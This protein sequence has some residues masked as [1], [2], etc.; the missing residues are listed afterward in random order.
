[1]ES[2]TTYGRSRWSKAWWLIPAGLLLLGPEAIARVVTTIAGIVTFPITGEIGVEVNRYEIFN[3]EL[4]MVYMIAAVGVNLIALPGLLSIGQAAFFGLGAYTVAI[5]T[6]DHGWNFWLALAAGAVLSALVSVVLAVPALR[7]GMFTLAMVTLG[8]GI[9]FQSM[10]LQLIDLT[11]GG[12]GIQGVAMPDAFADLESY[13]WLLAIVLG[14]TVALSVTVLRS[15]MGRQL[16]AVGSAP[17]AA[18][19]IGIHAKR[20]KLA[21]FAAAGFL[22]GLAGGLYAPLIGF[23]SPESFTVDL[24]ILLLLM[25]LL[26]GA[27]TIVGPLLGAVL[28]FRIPIEVNRVTDDPGNTS[29]LVYGI[30]LLL[31]VYL[32]PRGIM[33]LWWWVAAR[34]R[35]R[36]ASAVRAERA[37]ADIAQVVPAVETTGE[38]LRVSG[39][40]KTLGGVKA[41]Q[42]VTLTVAPGTVHALIGP[43]G[44]GKTTLLNII[45]G[46][47]DADKGTVEINGKV[48][49]QATSA[50]ARR[51]L[52][53]TFQV[54]QLFDDQSCLEN[55]LVAL[56][57][58]RRRSVLSY[59]L[60]F[61]TALREE[62]S[63]GDT[64]MSLLT[65]VGLSE[66]ADVAASSLPPGERRLL[67]V[68]RVV[69]TRPSFVL[70][71][72][73]AAGLNSAEIEE[74]KE[75]ILVLRG[76]GIGVLLVEHHMELVLEVSDDVTVVEFGKVISHGDP[77]H[78]R[79]DP[80]VIA[81]YLGEPAG[82]VPSVAARPSDQEPA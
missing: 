81:A 3:T 10:A 65:A 75:I 24:S 18:E 70:M 17:V 59:A 45:S 12:Q 57:T 1:M 49:P 68:A 19:S 38:G 51:G 60:R 73:P 14:L 55:I 42:E 52:S 5:T 40:A 9:V 35:S 56:D 11:H 67:E 25:V 8:Y 46:Y 28:L 16:K 4:L 34:I 78:I 79:N 23:V 30:V 61:P 58:R 26:G 39:V 44:A 69:A 71:D 31:S 62:R 77:E 53:R 76:R 72:E 6:V 33:S 13:Y 29:L 2:Y 27:G 66:H 63:Q 80:K 7:L 48:L 21:S 15:P 43:N 41:V 47:V 32:F 37:R 64:A 50:R 22:A 82:A 36:R 54:P 74:L 20:G